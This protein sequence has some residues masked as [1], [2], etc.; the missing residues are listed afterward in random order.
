MVKHSGLEVK[1][2]LSTGRQTKIN[3]FLVVILKFGGTV[4][5][6][7]SLE[8]NCMIDSFFL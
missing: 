8:E 6:I 1:V 7:H 4:H 5:N 3:V 2:I